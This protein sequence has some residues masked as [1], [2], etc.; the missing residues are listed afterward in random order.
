MNKN[1]IYLVIGNV[2]LFSG[3]FIFGVLASRSYYKGHYKKIA[4][5][6]IESVKAT[7]NKKKQELTEEAIVKKVI[8]DDEQ[9]N[10]DQESLKTIEK[11]IK[12]NGYRQEEDE[13]TDAII[14]SKRSEKD[15]SGVYVISPEEFGDCGYE[16]MDLTYYADG[17]LADDEDE[18]VDNPTDLVGRKALN[19][20]G[21]YED[22][23]VHVRSDRRKCDYEITT[24][25]RN[26]KDIYKF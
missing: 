13:I 20:F 5:E 3:G 19:S 10:I 8:E 26:W 25:P 4:D 18:M 9:F 6:E 15:E 17:V 23:V 24:D 22:G 11:I 2:S 14:K 12:D 1:V 16:L 7:V 21:E